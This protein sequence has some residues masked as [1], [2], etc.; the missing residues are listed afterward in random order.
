MSQFRVIEHFIDHHIDHTGARIRFLD[1]GGDDRGA[2]IIFVPGFTCV[3][4]DYTG[5]LPDLGRRVIVVELRG[6]GRSTAPKAPSTRT[7]SPAT[8]AQSSMP[9]PTV[10]C[11]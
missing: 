7:R 6:H 2:P 3:A 4:D 8:S 1:S 11:T 9:S 5:I 10:R